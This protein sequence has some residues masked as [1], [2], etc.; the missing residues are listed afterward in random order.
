MCLLLFTGAVFI[1]ALVVV[2][3]TMNVS[4]SWRVATESFKVLKIDIYLT[5]WVIN[6]LINFKALTFRR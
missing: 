5:Y 6:F 3:G 2:N 1:A 4:L